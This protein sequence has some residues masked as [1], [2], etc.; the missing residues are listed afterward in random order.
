M[1][2]QFGMS[3]IGPISFGP[4]IDMTEWGGRYMNETQISPEMLSRIDA[5]VKKI[6]DNCYQKALAILR[7][8]KTKLDKVAV[9]L[10]K[11]E[12]LEGDDFEKIMGSA[13]EQTPIA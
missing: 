2:V 10:L 8:E 4:N 6:L 13:K 5:E 12:T 9:E 1:V 3:D 7:K 11:K